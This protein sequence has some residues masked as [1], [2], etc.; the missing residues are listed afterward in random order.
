MFTRNIESRAN[1]DR[2]FRI[3]SRRHHQRQQKALEALLLRLHCSGLSNGSAMRL[4]REGGSRLY[5]RERCRRES[6]HSRPRSYATHTHRPIPP[7]LP[8]RAGIRADDMPVR[9]RRQSPPLDGRAS[10]SSRRFDGGDVDGDNTPWYRRGLNGAHG[11]RV[12]VG[13]SSRERE[14]QIRPEDVCP[15]SKRSWR[16]RRP[17]TV[18]RWSARLGSAT[19]R[20]GIS[21][22]VWV[23]CA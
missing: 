17:R 12:G 10:A 3:R 1:A 4:G 6:E 9:L 19:R 5:L 21:P 23:C 13:C 8:A 14:H 11:A 15:H 22:T 2:E 16:P 20:F 18:R 7:W